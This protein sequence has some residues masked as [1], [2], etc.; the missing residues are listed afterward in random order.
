MSNQEI[1]YNFIAMQ[2]HNPEIATLLNQLADLLEIQ[3][4][5]PFRIRAY[6]TAAR[7]IDELPQSV[8]DM[9]TEG[10]DL[11]ELP[12]I[13][14]AL[15]KKIQ[16][17]V[18]TGKLPQLQQLEKRTPQALTDLLM[19]EGLGP[20]RV[21]AL[22]DRLHIK[23]LDDLK[24]A[25]DRGKVSQ[26]EGF[27]KKTE[28]LILAG[29]Q[30]LNR[31]KRR[32]KL[33]DAEKISVSLIHFVKKIPGVKKADIAGSFRRRKETVGDLD[34]L[35]V[36]SKG[37]KVIDKFIQFD[38]ITR[39]VSHGTTKSTV[40]LRSGIQV[41]LRV[42]EEKSYGS[43]L[44]YFTGSKSHNIALRKMAIKKKWKVNE[45]GIFKG[46]KQ[47]AGKSEKEFYAAFGLPYIKPELRENRGEI[48]AAFKH[49]LPK[50]IQ[51]KDIRGDLHCHTDATDGQ[52]SL[53]EMAQAAKARG[54][55]YIAITDH[56]QHL[57]VARGLNKKR[58]TQ[59]I[60]KIDQLNAKLANFTV[61][62]SIEVD[63]LEDGSLDLPNDILK[64]LDLTVCSVHSKFNLSEKKQTERILRAMDNP[65][66]NILGHPFGR[67][68]GRRDAYEINIERILQAAKE[69][70][71]ILE[72]NAQPERMDLDDIHCKRAKEMGI[73][74]VISTDAHSTNHFSHM[75]F[76]V[77]IAR[78]GWLEKKNVINTQDLKG[79]KKSLIRK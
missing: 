66:F 22:Y 48:E 55:H 67:L 57:T 53:E 75:Q 9:L 26:L 15:A 46:N 63:I 72:I 71:C 59:Q 29:I 25:I 43:A 39:V 35:V 21:K 36:A 12:G 58:L 31:G 77:D 47:I 78:R 74:M 34:V 27:G 30:R 6:R 54:Y 14:D 8:A 17:I 51:L 19:I 38:E 23:N 41:D 7:L 24:Q 2:V 44:H 64:E 37:S 52:Y 4:E 40:Y 65:Y 10:R 61:L 18:K 56:S 28:A 11:T 73:K 68:I 5:N 33:S 62:K 79:L 49:Q 3:G 60:K 45:Y 70:G 20:K 76:G 13:G 50:L 32:I 42:V 1:N 16:T 69:R